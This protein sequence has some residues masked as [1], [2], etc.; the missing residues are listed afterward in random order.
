MTARGN[1]D[2]YPNDMESNLPAK[3]YA[4]ARGHEVTWSPHAA[5]FTCKNCEDSFFVSPYGDKN[6]YVIAAAGNRLNCSRGPQQ[7]LWDE[8]GNFRRER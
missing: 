5:R 6:P 2:V 3:R 8:G 4:E 1:D 7:D